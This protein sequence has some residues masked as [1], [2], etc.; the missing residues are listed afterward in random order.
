MN[1]ETTKITVHEFGHAFANLEDEYLNIKKLNY[2]NLRENCDVEGCPKWCTGE[3]NKSN[4]VCYEQY[5]KYKE[6][7]SD[8]NSA[9]YCYDLVSYINNVSFSL[10]QCDLGVGCKEGTSC[11][12]NCQSGNL[13]RSSN[14]GIMYYPISAEPFE[15]NRKIGRP[16]SDL[17][18]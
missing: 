12:W 3:L 16:C 17:L 10:E 6:C 1:R 5:T 8:G 9:L 13:F 11:Y 14:N 15:F 2:V 7:V 18:I 4:S